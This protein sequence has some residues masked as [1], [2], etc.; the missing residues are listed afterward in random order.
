MHCNFFNKMIPNQK[1]GLEESIIN[2]H[3]LKTEIDK[4]DKLEKLTVN[5]TE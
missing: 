3:L 2:S 1:Q 4:N 5:I